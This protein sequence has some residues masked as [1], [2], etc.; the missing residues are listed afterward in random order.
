MINAISKI[1][2]ID[3]ENERKLIKQP[4]GSTNPGERSLKVRIDLNSSD[5]WINPIGGECSSIK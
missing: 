2:I 4:P 3:N 5:R 1:P